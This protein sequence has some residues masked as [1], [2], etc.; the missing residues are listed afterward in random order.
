MWQRIAALRQFNSPSEQLEA[1][2]PVLEALFQQVGKALDRDLSTTEPALT[3][4]CDVRLTPG[5]LDER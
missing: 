1:I 2:T 4:R 5:G 3:F